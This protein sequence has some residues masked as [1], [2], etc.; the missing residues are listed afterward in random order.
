MKEGKP[1]LG[2]VYNPYRD[3]MFYA[4]EGKG[5]YLNG[6]RIRVSQNNLEYSMFCTAM[7]LYNKDFAKPCFNIME[8]VYSRCNYIRQI[9]SP[10]KEKL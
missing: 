4:E 8:K 6:R 1:V 10:A 5:A 9:G 2:V 3:E 7:S